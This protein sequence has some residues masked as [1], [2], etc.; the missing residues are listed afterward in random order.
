MDTEISPVSSE[1]ISSIRS[2]EAIQKAATSNAMEVKITV[3]FFGSSTF[4]ML[5]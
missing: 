1:T 5:R 2:W 4:M 3:F